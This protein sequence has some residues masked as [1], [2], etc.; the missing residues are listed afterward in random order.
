MN[1]EDDDD[2]I[3]SENTDDL[4]AEDEF[5]APRRRD[6]D[7]DGF[8]EEEAAAE[9]RAF[10]AKCKRMQDLL[11]VHRML[12]SFEHAKPW[13]RLWEDEDDPTIH[14]AEWIDA[15]YR[16]PV[17]L[18]DI[19]IAGKVAKPGELLKLMQTFGWTSHEQFLQDV[20]AGL[21]DGVIE[22]LEHPCSRDKL[23]STDA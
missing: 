6:N 1:Y 23:A 14:A 10:G 18:S 21:F 7:L 11:S 20:D 2:V 16:D 9:R 15:G 4:D 13:V 19:L 3:D 17:L 5:P 12:H 22:W 8:G